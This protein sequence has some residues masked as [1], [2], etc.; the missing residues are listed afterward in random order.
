MLLSEMIQ[1][2]RRK[3][4][5]TDVAIRDVLNNRR[6]SETTDVAIRDEPHKPRR[7]FS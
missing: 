1:I 7:S 5:T 2:N 6:K 3:S 4:E